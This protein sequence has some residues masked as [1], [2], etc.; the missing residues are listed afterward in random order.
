MQ[1]SRALRRRLCCQYS[2]RCPGYYSESIEYRS[3]WTWKFINTELA[4]EKV[5]DSKISGYVWKGPKIDYITI[6][7]R[8]LLYPGHFFYWRILS[9]L[10][11]KRT[12]WGLQHC[13]LDYGILLTWITET[14]I[15][16][17][18][19]IVCRKPECP[20]SNICKDYKDTFCCLTH[21]KYQ[22]QEVLDELQPWLS[23]V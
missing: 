20:F 23:P 14:L 7:S 2:Q 5:A 17:D 13:R 10:T 16:S 12:F 6:K 4:K 19:Q 8:Q 11:K 3:V 22:E 1:I 21:Y 15:T 18:Y 9:S